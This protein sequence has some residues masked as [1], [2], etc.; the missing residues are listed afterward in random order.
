MSHRYIKFT[1]Y[2]KLKKKDYAYEKRFNRELHMYARRYTWL[3]T[4]NRHSCEAA[5]ISPFAEVPQQTMSVPLI[6]RGGGEVC[7]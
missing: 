7:V 1:A 5:F 2:E 6:D 3:I 4:F